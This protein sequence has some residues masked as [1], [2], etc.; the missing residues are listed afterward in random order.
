MAERLLA[1][2]ASCYAEAPTAANGR[3]RLDDDDDA[4]YVEQR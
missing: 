1:V 2:L 3:Q 4:C